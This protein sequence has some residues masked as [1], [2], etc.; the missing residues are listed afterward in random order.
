MTATKK[1]RL[2]GVV[3]A[4]GVDDPNQMQGHTALEKAYSMGA[5]IR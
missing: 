5:S 1:A 4:G 3:F 2:A